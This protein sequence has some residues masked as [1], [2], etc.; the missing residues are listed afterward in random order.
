MTDTGT[1]HSPFETRYADRYLLSVWSEYAKV[2]MWHKYWL[3]KLLMLHGIGIAKLSDLTIKELSGLVIEDTTVDECIR[4]AGIFEQETHHDLAAALQAFAKVLPEEARPYI[5]LGN[6]SSD[7]EDW[8]DEMHVGMSLAHACRQLSE[9]LNMLVRQIGACKDL[10]IM[11]RTHLQLAEPTMLGYRFAAYLDQLISVSDTLAYE[12]NKIRPG[13]WQTGAVGTCS[14]LELVAGPVGILPETL[15]DVLG[16]EQGTFGATGQTYPR[17]E[18]LLWGNALSTMAAILHKMGL[19]FRLMYT[20]PW[21]RKSAG[22]VGSS[23][24]PGKVNPI[25]WEKVCSLAGLVHRNVQALWDVAANTALERTLDDSA[26]RRFLLPE[27]FMLVSEMLTTASRELVKLILVDP[28]QAKLQ[29]LQNW[30]AW[31][32][33]RALAYRQANP[34]IA[35]GND[36]QGLHKFLSE[37]ARDETASGPVNYWYMATGQSFQTDED[38]LDNVLCLKTAS[39]C[40]QGVCDRAT[41]AIARLDRLVEAGGHE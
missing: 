11:G 24:M 23:A 16:V 18:D 30:Q 33:S 15:L 2:A 19:D 4:R 41:Y 10:P 31:L 8:A 37:L 35:I 9:L 3:G 27:T 14:N 29:I 39:L 1:Y 7:P 6:T 26:A 21:F 36:R 32:P 5:H 38:L 20:E 34:D 28:L 22:G 17:S 40:C 13:K 12:A 25:A